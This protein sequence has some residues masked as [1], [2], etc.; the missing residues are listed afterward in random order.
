[1]RRRDVCG[2]ARSLC[3]CIRGN[4]GCW[5]RICPPLFDSYPLTTNS[6]GNHVSPYLGKYLKLG[7]T[8][9]DH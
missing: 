2:V 4:E 8:N 6:P 1:M 3:V 9:L 5:G 7:E